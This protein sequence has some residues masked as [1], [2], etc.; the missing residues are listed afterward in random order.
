MSDGRNV[1]VYGEVVDGQIT[2]FTKE[3]LGGGRTLADD[4]GEE[5]IAVFVGDTVNEAATLSYGFGADRVCVRDDRKLHYYQTDLYVF[6]MERIVKEELPRFILF[7]HTDAGADLGPRLSFRLGVPVTT[8]CVELSIDPETKRLLT[9]KPVCGGLAMATLTGDT[10]P[11]IAT[12]RPKSLSPAEWKDAREGKTVPIDISFDALTPR[13]EVLEKTVEE[14]QG[15][16]LGEAEVTVSGGR[17]IGGSEGFRVLEELA[18]LLRGT[19]G[20]SRVPCDSG[21]VPSTQQVGLTGT[22]VAPKLY[23]AVGISGASQHMTG[24]ARAKTIVAINSDPR[25]P[26][27]KEAQYG[28]VGDWTE[29]LPAFVNKIKA[30]A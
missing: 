17:G 8:D 13:A 9:T 20:A 5:L 30:M 21:W 23:V 29:I 28:I 1:M 19:V 15:M 18:Q 11:Q 10:L 22:I 7:G 4:L 12:V 24:C 26:I 3:L 14:A 25:A 6:S 2:S 16:K 27:F